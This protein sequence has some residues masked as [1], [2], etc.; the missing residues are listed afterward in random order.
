MGEGPVVLL[1]QSFVFQ[2]QSARPF[3]ARIWSALRGMDR[4]W[5]QF[6]LP[7][8]CWCKEKPEGRQ[9]QWRD[10]RDGKGR[11]ASLTQGPCLRMA[12]EWK[13]RG[14]EYLFVSGTHLVAEGWSYCKH[15]RWLFGATF[16]DNGIP[17]QVTGQPPESTSL[18]SQ[19]CYFLPPCL[20][21][22]AGPSSL[23]RANW[24]SVDFLEF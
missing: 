7:S 19:T 15:C 1:G 24:F 5:L 16:R 21:E 2:R 23:S 8:L 14:V 18:V 3:P 20:R 10:Q 17:F 11:R 4:D 12:F 6:E 22:K 9:G 13:K